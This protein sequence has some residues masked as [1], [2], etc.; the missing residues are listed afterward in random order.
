MP[1]D[2]DRATRPKSAPFDAAGNPA[3]A[4]ATQERTQKWRN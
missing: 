4:Q 1:Q 2:F 3:A